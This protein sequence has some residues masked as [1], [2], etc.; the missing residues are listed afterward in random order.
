MAFQFVSRPL[1][2]RILLG[3]SLSLAAVAA[4]AQEADVKFQKS[5]LVIATARGT[6][7]GA[8]NAKRRLS[9]RDTT[10]NAMAL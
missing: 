1:G 4:C 3:A 2:R 7:R 9:G 5:S 8:V 6:A 10:R